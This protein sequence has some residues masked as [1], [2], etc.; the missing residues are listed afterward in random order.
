MASMACHRCNA[1]LHEDGSPN[2]IELYLFP[3]STWELYRNT[4]K[5]VILYMTEGPENF[6]TVW[7]CPVC[8]CFH[9][10]SAWECHVIRCYL[11]VVLEDTPIIGNEPKFRLFDDRTFYMITEDELDA[12][13]LERSNYRYE[14]ATV[15]DEFIHIFA[16]KEFTQ[17]LRSLRFFE[18]QWS[19][20]IV[21][22]QHD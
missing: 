21:P 2:D 17:Y 5:P 16:D 10:F 12:E 18:T 6:F 20:S 9:L 1:R 11:P 15:T 13:R 19:Q 3:F 22:Y 7:Q 4:S 14:Y 8:G